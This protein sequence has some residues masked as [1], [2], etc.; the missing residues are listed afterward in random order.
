MKDSIIRNLFAY[1]VESMHLTYG[2][3]YA[4]PSKKYIVDTAKMLRDNQQVKISSVIVDGYEMLPI[5]CDVF[6]MFWQQTFMM[7]GKYEYQE[8]FEMI[9]LK[10]K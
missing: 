1:A 2:S 4:G 6:A 5:I 7:T 9:F 3:V 8:M 10:N